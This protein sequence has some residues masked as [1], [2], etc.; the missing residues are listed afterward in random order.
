MARRVA[1]LGGH[2][3]FREKGKGLNSKCQNYLFGKIAYNYRISAVI[4]YKVRRA[5][6]SA[7]FL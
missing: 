3:F 1:T 4:A 6:L 7:L 2:T 5:V